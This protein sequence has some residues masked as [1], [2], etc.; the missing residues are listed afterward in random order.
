MAGG[1]GPDGSLTTDPAAIEQ[2]SRMLPIGYWKGSG[3]SVLMDMIGAVLSGGNSVAQVGQ[4]G[5]EVGLTQVFLA[6]DPARFQ[7]AALTEQVVAAIT[8]DVHASQPE[9]PGGQV[10]CPG[11]GIHRAR[12]ENLALGIPAAEEKWNAVLAM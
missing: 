7:A 2:T 3:L 12:R 9:T 11:E 8:A 1:Y 6:L 5:S 4:L 10:R